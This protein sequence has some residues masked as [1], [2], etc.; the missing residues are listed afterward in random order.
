MQ[1]RISALILGDKED[2]RKRLMALFGGD[3]PRGGEPPQPA[4]AWARGVLGSD[5][6]IASEAEAVRRLR[7]AEPRL[8]L[9][10]AVFLA[11]H[12]RRAS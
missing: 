12:A 9:K 1:G 6:Q 8:A 2:P 7:A 4:L 5:S 10:P 11:H 3:M